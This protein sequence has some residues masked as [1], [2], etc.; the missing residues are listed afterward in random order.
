MASGPPVFDDTT[1]QA[2]PA[3]AENEKDE[4]ARASSRTR[5]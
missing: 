5:S 1:R 2:K 4:H 3:L